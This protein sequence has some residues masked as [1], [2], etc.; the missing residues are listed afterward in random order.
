MNSNRDH[1]SL[2]KQ[3][4]KTLALKVLA[5]ALFVKQIKQINHFYIIQYKP[6]KL[7]IMMQIVV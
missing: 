3:R 7:I 4:D 6:E 1:R 2:I 5:N